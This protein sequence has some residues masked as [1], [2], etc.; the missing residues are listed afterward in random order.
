MC[1]VWSNSLENICYRNKIRKIGEQPS[2][3]KY[4]DKTS[5]TFGGIFI[6]IFIYLL[7]DGIRVGYCIRDEFC[8]PAVMLELIL[9]IGVLLIGIGFSLDE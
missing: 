2:M 6:G 4:I 7:Y 1:Y 8:V 3:I 9:F 5:T